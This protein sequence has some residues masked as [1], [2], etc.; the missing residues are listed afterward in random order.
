MTLFNKIS[1]LRNNP[2]VIR[3]I[4]RVLPYVLVHPLPPPCALQR[5]LPVRLFHI[6]RRH[7]GEDLSELLLRTLIPI[8]LIRLG[9]SGF[10]TST[11]PLALRELRRPHEHPPRRHHQL[12]GI[13]PPW[14]LLQAPAHPQQP[15]V[16][17]WVFC[18][19]WLAAS[20]SRSANSA[21]NTFPDQ[22]GEEVPSSW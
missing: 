1:L 17:D 13:H 2:T 21:R 16:L 10:T 6:L 22:A 18:S 5:R 15:V 12:P 9:S 11:R 8:V 7:S 19:C 3:A 4:S 20:A 14:D